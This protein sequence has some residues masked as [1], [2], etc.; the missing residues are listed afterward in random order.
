MGLCT[1]I[2]VWRLDCSFA[3]AKG[4]LDHNLH[5]S[6]QLVFTALKRVITIFDVSKRALAANGLHQAP[7]QPL[8]IHRLGYTL[9]F[10]SH[11]NQRRELATDWPKLG[12]ESAKRP[13]SMH[14]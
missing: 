10:A 14:F 8:S 11:H 6:H 5:R 2:E 3:E 12:L 1:G 9:V 7:A 13:L 4:I